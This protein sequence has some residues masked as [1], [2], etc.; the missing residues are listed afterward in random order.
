MSVCW[1]FFKLTQYWNTK[2]LYLIL[3]KG[4]QLVKSLKQFS[5]LGV[6][7]VNTKTNIESIAV[8]M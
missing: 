5:C 3:E 2:Y 1:T 7:D 8:F 6:D 4:D